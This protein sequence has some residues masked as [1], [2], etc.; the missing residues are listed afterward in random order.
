MLQTT[1]V[2]EYETG[3]LYENG[4]FVRALAAG[5]YQ[6]WNG[7]GASRHITRVDIRQTNV[8]VNG[9]EMLTADKITLRLNLAAAYRVVD[10]PLAVNS[11]QSY[12]LALYTELQLALRAAVT[13]MDLDTLM[14]DRDALAADLRVRVQPVALNLGLSLESVGVRDIILPGEVKKMLARE[15]EALREGRAALVAAREETAAT[16]AALNTARMLAENPVLMQVKAL[17]SLETVAS[18]LGN[19][20]VLTLPSVL[21]ELLSGRQA[22]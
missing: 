2:Q 5:R 10:A 3:L 14:A 13:A 15:A 22:A 19:T 21:T 7:F 9:Q 8:S 4:R 11:V 12:V 17:Q 18:G 20:V 6:L 1:I 16:R